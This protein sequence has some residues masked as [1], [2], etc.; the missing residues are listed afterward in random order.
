VSSS[1]VIPHPDGVD[2]SIL[3]SPPLY[4]V[5][6]GSDSVVEQYNV[7]VT[8]CITDVY[9]APWRVKERPF[10]LSFVAGRKIWLVNA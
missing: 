2:H 6:C 1:A 7:K 4:E 9:S 8:V 3:T 5:N 10:G